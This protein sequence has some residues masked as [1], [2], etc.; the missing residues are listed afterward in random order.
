MLELLSLNG[1]M[2]GSPSLES[3]TLVCAMFKL[4]L[5]YCRRHV[6][7]MK[8]DARAKDL[9]EANGNSKFWKG[10]SR[11]MSSKVTRFANKGGHAVGEQEVCDM[12]KKHLTIS[13]IPYLMVV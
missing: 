2:T 6:D 3:P 10:I 13:I 9:L 7:Q 1:Y 12:W 4:A 11:D 8:A 5:R